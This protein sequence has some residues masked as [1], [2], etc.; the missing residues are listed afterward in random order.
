M[1]YSY[2]RLVVHCNTGGVDFGVGNHLC[3]VALSD[4]ESHT[5]FVEPWTVAAREDS[6]F[7]TLPPEKQALLYD[8]LVITTHNNGYE[9]VRPF[10]A[11]QNLCP[12][13]FTY[14]NSFV[15]IRAMLDADLGIAL[16][17][18]GLQPLLSPRIR[19]QQ[20]LK[21]PLEVPVMVFYDPQNYSPCVQCLMECC[22]EIYPDMD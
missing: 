14:T 17:P 5:L 16:L 10:C 21:A 6:A 15:S 3:A 4:I 2:S 11:S 9:P 19:C 13:A 7:W 1:Y 8:Q 20:V 18:E 12:K 22:R